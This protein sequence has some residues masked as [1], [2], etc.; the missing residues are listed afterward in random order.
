MATRER[1]MSAGPG[2]KSIISQSQTVNGL[3]REDR[4]LSASV[5]LHL[6]SVTSL[7]C[8]PFFTYEMLYGYGQVMCSPKGLLGGNVN[9]QHHVYNVRR[10]LRQM[11]LH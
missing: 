7:S 9:S 2:V 11:F 3:G 10:Q 8:L 4:H 5:D 1:I 6:P